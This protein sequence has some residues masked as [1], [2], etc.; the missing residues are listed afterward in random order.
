MVETEGDGGSRLAGHAR[1]NRRARRAK[2]SEKNTHTRGGTFVL[3]KAYI[4][5]EIPRRDRKLKFG[6]MISAMPF[7]HSC[8]FGAKTGVLASSSFPAHHLSSTISAPTLSTTHS[9]RPSANNKLNNTAAKQSKA[10]ERQAN[11][12][13]QHCQELNTQQTS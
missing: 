1:R 10:N 11:I 13:K 12:S 6:S 3:N 5:M 2:S 4:F 7:R 8:F 9:S